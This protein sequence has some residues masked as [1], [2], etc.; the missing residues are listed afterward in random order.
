M[1]EQF[2]AFPCLAGEEVTVGEATWVAVVRCTVIG[3]Q[4]GQ[5]ILQRVDGPGPNEGELI[6]KT[7][8]KESVAEATLK[9]Y[10]PILL[11]E[12]IGKK[13]THHT[14]CWPGFLLICEDKSYVKLEP[15]QD[16]GGCLDLEPEKLDIVDLRRL[17]LLDEETLQKIEDERNKVARLEAKNSAE[18][19]LQGAISFLGE[20]R[21]QEIMSLRAKNALGAYDLHL[22]EGETT[23]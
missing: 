5:P 1:F 9:Q 7:E 8:P 21:V 23:R 2:L 11:H 12:L 17:K 10:K 3:Q 19:R 13:I 18:G 20:D 14:K 6:L 22:R 16:C 15:G 4:D